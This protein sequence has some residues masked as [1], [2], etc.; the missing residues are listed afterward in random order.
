MIFLKQLYKITAKETHFFKT[1][2]L[3]YSCCDDYPLN[4]PCLLYN[5]SNG[6]DIY[7][8]QGLQQYAACQS[9]AFM[10]GTASFILG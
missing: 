3:R 6:D 2:L 5:N 1:R 8:P 10:K 9:Y 7:C 4:P